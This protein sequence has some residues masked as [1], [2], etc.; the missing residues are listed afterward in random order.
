MATLLLYCITI[1]C[2]LRHNRRLSLLS[3]DKFSLFIFVRVNQNV[4]LREDHA[5]PIFRVC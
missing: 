5:F 2:L 3:C 1:T 4:S